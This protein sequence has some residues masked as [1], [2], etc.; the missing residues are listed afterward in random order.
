MHLLLIFFSIKHSLGVKTSFRE[1]NVIFPLNS[2]CHGL[3]GLAAYSHDIYNN[4]PAQYAEMLLIG[5]H[6]QDCPVSTLSEIV[7]KEFSKLNH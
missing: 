5:S 2:K 6:F 4:R 1:Q 7:Y 3:K